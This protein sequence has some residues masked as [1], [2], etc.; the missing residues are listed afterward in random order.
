MNAELFYETFKEGLAF[1][2]VGFHN[3][4]LVKVSIKDG[5]FSMSY[6][7]KSCEIKLGESN[8]PPIQTSQKARPRP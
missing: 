2:G 7:G 5:F 6:S 3:K 8:V 4:D 1:L